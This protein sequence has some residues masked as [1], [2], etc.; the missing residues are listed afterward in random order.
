MTLE[1]TISLIDENMEAQAFVQFVEGMVSSTQVFN[2]QSKMVLI[3]LQLWPLV[4]GG[5]KHMPVSNGSILNENPQTHI[6]VR[7]HVMG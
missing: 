7:L 4:V 3:E 5:I 6:T 1:E 2:K